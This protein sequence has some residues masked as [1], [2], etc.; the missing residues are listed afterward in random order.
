MIEH[1]RYAYHNPADECCGPPRL[2]QLAWSSRRVIDLLRYRGR[3]PL[4]LAQPGSAALTGQE[5]TLQ[6][7]LA[8]VDAGDAQAALRHAQWLV[9]T[10]E[11]ARLVRWAQ[12][13][14]ET[15]AKLRIAA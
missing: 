10:T 15:G 11:A 9:P 12:P 3:R 13:V 6:A 1:L 7:L 4:H 14:V 2:R 8:A 5:L